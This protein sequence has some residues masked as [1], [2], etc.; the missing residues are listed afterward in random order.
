MLFCVTYYQLRTSCENRIM[1]AKIV[2]ICTNVGLAT[3]CAIFTIWS[4]AA[5]SSRR[6]TGRRLSPPRARVQEHIT[7]ERFAISSETGGAGCFVGRSSGWDGL[8]NKQGGSRWY[9]FFFWFAGTLLKKKKKKKKK[10]LSRCVL[11]W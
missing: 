11:Y 6:P 5:P 1:S 7:L 2:L 4:D 10:K 3:E 9:F 8:E